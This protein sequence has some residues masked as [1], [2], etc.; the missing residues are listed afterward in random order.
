MIA[1][2][3]KHGRRFSFA[4]VGF[5]A[6]ALVAAGCAEDRR[7]SKAGATKATGKLVVPA[8]ITP[9][10][11]VARIEGAPESW[12]LNA[13]VAKALRDRDVPAGTKGRGKASYTLEGRASAHA[14]ARRR[15]AAAH[16]LGALRCEGQA[17]GWGRP[18]R[19]APDCGRDQARCADA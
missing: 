13:R 8:R 17:R 1:D 16:R 11:T 18:D 4:G 19:S 3:G 14:R 2:N 9:P 5:I 10:V 12:Q 6:L 15:A 7:F